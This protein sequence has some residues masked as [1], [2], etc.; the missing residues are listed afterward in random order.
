MT[1]KSMMGAGGLLM[2]AGMTGFSAPAQALTINLHDTGGVTG[3]PAELGFKI[4]ASYWEKTLTNNA[5]LNLDVGYEDLG[6]DVLGSTG[7]NLFTY[8]PIDLY[9]ALLAGGG[10]SALDATAV[11]HLSPLSATG[12][13]AMKVPGYLNASGLPLGIDDTSTRYAPDG[14]AI[15]QTL[16]LST[17][18]V[19][20][21][22]GGYED[23]TDASIT[24]SSTFAFDFNP[25]D[26]IAISSYDF[27]GVAIHEIGHAL[28]FLSGADDFDY[29]DGYLGSVDD[30]WW[31]YG[32]DMFRYSQDRLGPIIDLAPGD[33]AYF[34]IDGGVTPYSNGFFSTG[35]NFGDGWQASHWLSPGD[36]SAFLGIMN[37]YVCNGTNAVVTGL[38]LAALDAI[39][40]NLSANARDKADYL[41]TTAQIYAD[42]V[43]EPATW[44]M[45]IAGFA[46]IGVSLR[47]RKTA[48]C[49]A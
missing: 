15:T 13:V 46:L 49:Y 10:T 20:A 28:G 37:P 41:K 23:L 22:I 2:A 44:A 42:Y 47:Q 24:F 19:K 11:A 1:L 16:A 5:V 26:G 48:V 4:A 25:T 30:A 35:T 32:L 14:Q 43:P 45:M 36:C 8:V 12:S 6:P 34:S 38:D 7:S 9:Y 18:N 33:D 31:A 39:G 21:L 29:S 27:I 17:A 3:S 40:W